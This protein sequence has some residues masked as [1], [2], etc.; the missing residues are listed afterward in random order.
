M[1]PRWTVWLLAL[2]AI[3]TALQW[4]AV[5]T[6]VATW[7]RSDTFA[8]GFLILPISLWLA[9]QDRAA[10][11]LLP[12]KPTPS[13]LLLC[14]FAG[15]LGWLG[16]LVDAQVVKELAYVATLITGAWA[17]L[18]HRL[19]SRLAFPLGFLFLAVPMGLSLEPPMMDL[20]ADWTVRL[21]TLTGIPVYQ[22]GRFFYLP[23]GSWSVVEACSGVRYLIASFTLGMLYAYL[24]YRTLWRRLLLVLL[25]VVVPIIANILRAYGIVMLG[26]FSDM[27]LATGVDHLVY[28][29]L[30]FGV[31]MLLLFFLGNLWREPETAPAGGQKETVIAAGSRAAV[32]DMRAL[33]P[34]LMALL[35]CAALPLVLG[36]LA[37]RADSAQALPSAL[38]LPGGLQLV[39]LTTTDWTPP[40][41]GAQRHLDRAIIMRDDTA[42]QLHI[43]QF[44]DQTQGAAEL[45]AYGDLWLESDSRWKITAR[46]QHSVGA[47]D[48]LVVREVELADPQGERLLAWSW[49]RVGERRATSAVGV[50]LLE[51]WDGLLH[52][53]RRG[54]QLFVASP[55]RDNTVSPA[56]EAARGEMKGFLIERG[57]ALVVALEAGLP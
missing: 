23:S 2:A 18:G 43:R 9:W 53:T 38:S 42:L 32:P 27:R 55:L 11:Q 17:L 54:A 44:T 57:D 35:A 4:S 31:V 20:T 10:L 26:H 12:W 40:L 51:A 19:A 56:I 13:V 21:I 36:S 30:F 52:G 6:M 22:E 14:F 33:L 7:A 41:R 47:L 1:M 49:Y 34:V 25:S 45:V 28:G 8:H 48:G 16:A 39:E 50:K 29:W 3:D 37:Q 15:I 5:S 24:N 46:R